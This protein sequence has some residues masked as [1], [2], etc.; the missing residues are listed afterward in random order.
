MQDTI[1]HN[2]LI[3][4]AMLELLAEKPDG[5][6]EDLFPEARRRVTQTLE[7]RKQ[8]AAAADNHEDY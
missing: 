4:S 2:Y 1:R 3:L 5:Q 6:I 8:P 7:A